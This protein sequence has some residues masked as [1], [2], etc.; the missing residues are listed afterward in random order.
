MMETMMVWSGIGLLFLTVTWLAVFDIAFK[1][2]PTKA[3][4][5]I[6]GVAVCLLP[7]VGCIAY[8]AVGFW[9]GKRK[10]AQPSDGSRPADEN[11]AN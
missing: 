9:T 4:K 7:F 2:F 11:N 8:F 3:H 6:W 5:W 1:E 10:V